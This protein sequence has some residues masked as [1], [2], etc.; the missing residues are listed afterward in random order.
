[1]PGPAGEHA[2]PQRVP[3]PLAFFHQ[4]L[5]AVKEGDDLQGYTP[6]VP[7][8]E[9]RQG[10]DGNYHEQDENVLGVGY[11]PLSGTLP[12]STPRRRSGA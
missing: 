12:G 8:R 6:E 1:M 2:D 11:A 3:V 4:D 10:G 7:S 9:V 5:D